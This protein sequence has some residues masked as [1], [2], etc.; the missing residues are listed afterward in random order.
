MRPITKDT[1]E[2]DS[3]PGLNMTPLAFR[4]LRSRTSVAQ[5]GDPRILKGNS[6]H[7]RK[8]DSS[9]YNSMFLMVAF[10]TPL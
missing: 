1:F 8:R 9:F 3:G 6:Y 5:G 4:I 10:A 7:S 2:Y